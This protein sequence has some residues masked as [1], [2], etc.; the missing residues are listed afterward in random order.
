MNIFEKEFYNSLYSIYHNEN[1]DLQVNNSDEK[2]ECESEN[3]LF[4]FESDLEKI[5]KFLSINVENTIEETYRLVVSFLKILHEVHKLR[6]SKVLKVVDKIIN[7]L[8]MINFSISLENS[9]LNE[10]SLKLVDFNRLL[11]RYLINKI[12]S[13]TKLN[14][15]GENLL[16]I[17]NE[18][19]TE[20]KEYL[21][22]KES[23]LFSKFIQNLEH[24]VNEGN[25]A[26]QTFSNKNLDINELC[27]SIM[28]ELHVNFNKELKRCLLNIGVTNPK[29]NFNYVH[30]KDKLNYPFYLKIGIKIKL[31]GSAH[32]LETSAFLIRNLNIYLNKMNQKRKIDFDASCI[33]YL[34]E[35]KT[36]TIKTKSPI[37]LSKYEDGDHTISLSI[38]SRLK[39][40]FVDLL[41]KLEINSTIK[42]EIQINQQINFVITY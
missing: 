6:I 10:S 20:S 22:L 15:E 41:S 16:D 14:E 9:D 24:E 31:S 34:K 32:L 25:R 13:I 37:Y 12:K 36:L 18:K 23:K 11:C 39:K 5:S 35:D 17:R 3:S 21:Q 30:T 38:N 26:I 40:D 42:E 4:I 28:T 19:I 27:E 2:A 8:E 7:I 29:N 33:K 1:L